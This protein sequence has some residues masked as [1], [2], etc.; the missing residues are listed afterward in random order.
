MERDAGKGSGV[1]AMWCWPTRVGSITSAAFPI[2][3]RVG[4]VEE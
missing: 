2:C 1:P 3:A 4:L